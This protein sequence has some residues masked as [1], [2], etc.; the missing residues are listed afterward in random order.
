MAGGALVACESS[1]TLQMSGRAPE[2]LISD[3]T[4]QNF[5]A[6]AHGD[7]IWRIRHAPAFGTCNNI[8]MNH[9]QIQY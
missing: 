8:G 1:G 4:C 7:G 3:D 5:D 6:F 9:F 2:M